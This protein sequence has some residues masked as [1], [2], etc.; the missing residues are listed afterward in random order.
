MSSAAVALQED[1]EKKP[2]RE[3]R[4][5]PAMSLGVHKKVQK[6]QE[7]M[8]GTEDEP[9][10]LAEARQILAELR[11]DDI[12]EYEMA[13]T[14][15]LEA[16]ISYEQDNP[17]GTI[18]AYENILKYRK[19]IP[20]ALELQIMFGLAQLYF[21]EEDYDKSLEMVKQWIPRKETISA[22]QKTFISQLYY[23][24]ENYDKALE[25]IYSAI[26]EAETDDTLEVKESWYQLALSSHWEQ[27][28]FEKVRD[29]LEIMIVNWPKPVYWTQ[30]AGVYGELGKNEKSFSITEAAYKQGFLDEKPTQL[31]N[32]AQILISREA[33]IKAAWVME[34]AFKEK[35]IEP[36][37]KNYKVLGQSYLM[38]QELEKA[39][40]P[41]SKNAEMENDGQMWLQVG[42][43]QM[44]LGNYSEAAAAFDEAVQA[45]DDN[46]ASE[47]DILTAHMQRGSALLEL[48]RFDDARRAFQKAR[49]LADT[50]SERRR[51]RQWMGYLE[52]E[53]KREEML[54]G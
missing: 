9:P 35:L 37:A 38:A 23:S 28:Q 36:T 25:Y 40:D 53:V 11:E 49:N 47:N 39:V 34:K 4:K 48:K 22:S 15:Q 51:A 26:N 54:T 50:S 16:M 13:V 45:Y 27:N 33:P 6:A 8:D 44:Q 32:L 1:G 43:V 14:W 30:L 12:N 46:D 29:V 5:V 2:E 3:T 10:N 31:V 21:S 19:S 18:D 7:A 20:V 52:K 42:Q 41:L 17:K 24:V